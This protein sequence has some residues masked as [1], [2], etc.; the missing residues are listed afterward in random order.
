MCG[1]EFSYRPVYKAGTPSRLPAHELLIGITL[2]SARLA[3]YCVRV[4]GT[5]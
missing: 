3:R 1:V 4:R 2:R 5:S